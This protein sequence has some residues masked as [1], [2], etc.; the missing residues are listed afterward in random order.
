MIML[1]VINLGLAGRLELG[2]THNFFLIKTVFSNLVAALGRWV[3]LLR[4]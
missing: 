4:P 3:V 2:F 1:N